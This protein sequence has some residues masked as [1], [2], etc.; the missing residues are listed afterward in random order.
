MSLSSEKKKTA[1][2]IRLVAVTIT[3]LQVFTAFVAARIPR[4]ASG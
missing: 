4:R 3:I 2:T 1:E